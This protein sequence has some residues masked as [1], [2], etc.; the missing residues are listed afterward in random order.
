MR[1]GNLFHERIFT[2][3]GNVQAIISKREYNYKNFFWNSVKIL[4][5]DR[6]LLKL[7]KGKAWFVQYEP[8]IFTRNRH[9]YEEYT[10]M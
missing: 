5:M 8:A 7:L 1:S 6:T 9:I 10:F 2:D 3:Y 4:K